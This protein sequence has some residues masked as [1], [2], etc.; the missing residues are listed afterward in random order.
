MEDNPSPH[1]DYSPE[2]ASSTG[3]ERDRFVEAKEL[4]KRADEDA[5]ILANRIAL[6]KAEE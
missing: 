4:R 6:L 5:K 3:D 1:S 2:Q